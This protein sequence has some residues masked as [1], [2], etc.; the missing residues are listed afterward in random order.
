MPYRN[1]KISFFLMLFLVLN[2][3]AAAAEFGPLKGRTFGEG[4]SYVVVFLH[5][6]VSR[7]GPAKYHEALMEK[8]ARGSKDA[9]TIALL[10]PGYENGAGLKSPGTNHK[11]RDQY[12]KKNNDLVA[13]TLKSLRKSYPEAK[14][15]VAGH[16]GGSAQLGAVI[17]RYPGIVDTAILIACPCDIRKWRA[18]HRPFR[19]SEKQSPIKFASKVAKST[20]VI[21]MTGEGDDNT[22]PIYGEAYAKKAKK[23]GVDA[24]FIEIKRGDHWNHYVRET[25]L[26]TIRSEIDWK[27][28]F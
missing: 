26:K 22:L 24:T 16:S 6:D 15:V 28:N 27:P 21:A 14:L 8:I 20:R 9:T 5:G 10:R 25:V 3:S 7:G 23:A 1:A 4:T 12:T 19:R 2:V 17:G 13:K 18:K 11:R